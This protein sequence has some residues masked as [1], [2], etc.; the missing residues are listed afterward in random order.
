MDRFRWI[1]LQRER[2]REREREAAGK[3]FTVNNLQW[4]TIEDANEI[5]P[6]K[7]AYLDPL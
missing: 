6:M 2:E 1:T 3:L 5:F 4:T 7:F